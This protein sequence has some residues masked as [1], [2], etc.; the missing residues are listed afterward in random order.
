MH[1]SITNLTFIKEQIK[2]KFSSSDNIKIIAVSKTFPI[3]EIEPLLR[4]GHV[5][6]GENKVQEAISKWMNVKNNFENVKLHMIGK[7][8]SNK[9]KFLIPLFDY[10]HSL[11]SIKLAEKI[12][13][14]Q[15]KLKKKIKIFIQVN[16][17][18][19]E[20]KNGIQLSEVENFYNICVNNL[21]LDIVGLMCLPPDKK[22][23]KPFFK[24]MKGLSDHLGLKELSMGMSSDYLDAIEFGASFIRIGSKIFGNRNQ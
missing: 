18:N 23:V 4:H 24:E 6:F 7:L 11:D 3:T 1:N 16:I 9:V 5:H 15:I 10:L 20:Q 21:E 12:S 14:E 8:Q 2:T 19:E 13:N 17:G 22:N